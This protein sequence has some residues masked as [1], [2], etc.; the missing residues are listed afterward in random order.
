MGDG[1]CSNNGNRSCKRRSKSLSLEDISYFPVFCSASSVDITATPLT[2]K[3][4]QLRLC[5]VLGMLINWY[6]RQMKSSI[7][8]FN[9]KCF[10]FI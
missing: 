6:L 8:L 7:R 3:N 4:K 2:E 9:V 5:V 10:I 1:G